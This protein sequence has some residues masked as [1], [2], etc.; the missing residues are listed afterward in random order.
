MKRFAKIAALLLALGHL[1]VGQSANVVYLKSIQVRV[2]GAT[3]AYSLDPLNAEASASNGLVTITGKAPGPAKIMVVTPDGVRALGVTVLQ[4]PP[5]YPPGFVPPSI[6]SDYGNS[7]DY[8]FRYS[9][10]PSQFQNNLGL[11]WRNGARRTEL[12]VNN[13]NLLRADSGSRI[14]FP[15]LSYAYSSPLREVVLL[16]QTVDNSPLTVEGAIV[17]GLHYRQG[18]WQFHAGV[19]SQT[20]FHEF[21]LSSDTEE[22]GGASRSFRVGQHSEIIPSFYYFRMPS[23]NSPGKGGAVGS[24]MYRFKASDEF[25]YALEVGASRGVGA[26]GEIRYSNEVNQI[27]ADF[28]IAPPQFAGLGVNPMRGQTVRADINHVFTRRLTTS[29]LFTRMKYELPGGATS[30]TTG[31]SLVRLGLTRHWSVNGGLSSSQFTLSTPGPATSTLLT[32]PVGIDFVRARFGAGVQYQQQIGKSESMT[33]SKQIRGNVSVGVGRAQVTAYVSRQTNTPALQTVVTN[34]SPLQDVIGTQ[35]ALADTPDTITS[36]LHDNLILAGLGYVKSAG[37]AIARERLQGGASL[38]WTNQR[39]GQFSYNLLLSRDALA[40]GSTQYQSHTLVYTRQLTPNNDISFA[41]SLVSVGSGGQHAY[42]PRFQVEGRHRFNSLP[43]FL[44]PGSTGV[45]SGHIFQDDAA[46]GQY[47]QTL[48]GIEDVEIVLDGQKSARS[49]AHGYYSFDHV[50]AGT[51]QVRAIPHI[52]RPYYFT[53]SSEQVTEIN[54]RVNF[55]IAFAAGQL[56]GF[57]RNDARQPI[58]GV[59]VRIRNEKV[60]TSVKSGDDGR[61]ERRSL[62]QGAYEVAIDA[63]SLPAGYWLAG[64]RSV[65]VEVSP[66]ASA[67]ADFTMKAVRA[68]GGR[69]A[70]YDSAAGKEVGVA[71]AVVTLH[72]IPC[73]VVTDKNGLYRFKELPA[74]NYTVSVVHKGKEYTVMVVLSNDP[75]LVRDANINVGAK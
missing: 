6:I 27:H 40:S 44:A 62:P 29:V 7:G 45:I 3:A 55:G 57:V 2:P 1:A 61:F 34:G 21:L 5:S 22:V 67:E 52:R 15:T 65:T 54:S 64:L 17:R 30:S 11:I 69:I 12:R 24:L 31:S 9:S 60:D 41:F 35:T 74:G 56:F 73:A 37:L 50:P 70:A 4:P 42:H 36:G 26:A 71:G 72:E 13:A 18:A 58:P 10:D 75:S 38:G 8:E 48:N 14:S 53:T 28:R 23:V 59:V 16:D 39:L 66:A 19:T 33:A 32:L 47:D 51:H 20:S 43:M 49:D 25:Q 68:L 46:S 63:A